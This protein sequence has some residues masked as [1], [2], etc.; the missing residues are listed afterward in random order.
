M[1]QEKCWRQKNPK[2]KLSVFF[3][4]GSKSKSGLK[5]GDWNAQVRA[6]KGLLEAKFEAC[7]WSYLNEKVIK[8][9][10]TRTYEPQTAM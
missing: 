4:K 9:T 8:R 5:R 6:L 10:A 7:L 2:N 1:H 3:K